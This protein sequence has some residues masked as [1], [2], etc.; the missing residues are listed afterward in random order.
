MTDQIPASI[1]ESVKEDFKIEL[2]EAEIQNK[3][4][5]EFITWIAKEVGSTQETEVIKAKIHTLVEKEQKLQN[6][7]DNRPLT[8]APFEGLGKQVVKLTDN[9]NKVLKLQIKRLKHGTH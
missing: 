5:R 6:I 9:I 2:R 8:R 7:S 1:H 4:Y 3:C